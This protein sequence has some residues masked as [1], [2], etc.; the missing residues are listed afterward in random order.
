MVFKKGRALPITTLLILA[1]VAMVVIPMILSRV[2]MR[3]GFVDIGES[4]RGYLVAE[5]VDFDSFLSV[6]TK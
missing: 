4:H 2:G 5:N 3:A 6:M 1:V